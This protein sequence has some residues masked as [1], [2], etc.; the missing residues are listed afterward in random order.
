MHFIDLFK[1]LPAEAAVIITSALPIIEV[2]GAVPLGYLY[3]KLSPLKVILLSTIGGV[4][5][6]FPILWFLENI[7]EGLRKIKIF[8]RFF[9]RLFEHT[10][11][12]SGIIEKFELV[13]LTLFMA[14]PIPGTGVW[15][16]CIAAYLLDLPWGSTFICA[17]IATLIA[18]VAVMVAT[19]GFIKIF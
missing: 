3:Y 12:K 15:T 1:S 19:L 11:A 17:V 18:S 14:L 13:G 8:D 7:T 6:V 2:R 4:L 16:G 9:E 5:P 10:R